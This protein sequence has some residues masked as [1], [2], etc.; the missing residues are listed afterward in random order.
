MKC[1][2]NDKIIIGMKRIEKMEQVTISTTLTLIYTKSQTHHSS[3]SRVVFR[4]VFHYNAQ[5]TLL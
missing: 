1:I 3:P 4:I 5:M 2:V